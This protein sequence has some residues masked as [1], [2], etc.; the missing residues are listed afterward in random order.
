MKNDPVH[1]NARRRSVATLLTLLAA[2]WMLASCKVEFSP[3]G[4]W[5][6]IP[7]VYCLL[8]QDDDTTY[9]R[10]QRCFMGEGNQY[11][12]AANPDSNNYPQGFI[13][14]QMEEWLTWKDNAGAVHY[15]GDAPVQIFDFQYATIDKQEGAFYG[16]S[17]P[18][19]VCPTAGQLDSGRYYRLV[20]TQTA[21][22]DTIAQAETLLLAGRIRLNNPN[23]NTLFRFTGTTNNKSC[24]ITF[25]PIDNGRKYQ[26]IVR[27]YY[28]DFVVTQTG[29]IPDTLITPHYIDIKCPE[30]K[31][32]MTELILT[33]DLSQ[34]SFLGAI[35]SAITDTVNKNI[36][37]TVDIYI[38][39]CNQDLS[40]YMYSTS[41]TNT[42]NQDRYN[43]TNIE[44]GLG[45]FAA[46]RTHIYFTVRTPSSQ[47]D[48]YVKQIASLGLGF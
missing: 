22:G 39:C 38:Q 9:V 15:Y 35:R 29:G 44:G 21:T 45:I 20:I 41:P 11:Q 14:V 25:T 16:G 40:A 4:Q 46:R 19:Y 1:S 32:N 26:P 17:Q 12:F 37:D 42:I 27:F 31:S 18:V 2:T 7:V 5:S 43:Y 36:V 3:N 28:R 47:N 8:D 6:N 24:K 23:S 33:S 13:T 30:V 48:D 34:S 10:V